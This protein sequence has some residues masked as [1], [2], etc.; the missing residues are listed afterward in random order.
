MA[1]DRVREWQDGGSGRTEG[2]VDVLHVGYVSV[3][4]HGVDGHDG[5]GG[6]TDEWCGR[7]PQGD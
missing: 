5:K 7:G 6:K 4:E 2:Q 1:K 3:L